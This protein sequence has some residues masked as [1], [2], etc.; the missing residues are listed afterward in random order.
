MKYLDKFLTRQ[1]QKALLAICGLTLLGFILGQFDGFHNLL[2]KKSTIPENTQE[3]V[4]AVQEDKPIQI[5]IRTATKEELILLPGIGEKRAQD[6]I[7]YRNQ[8]GFNST[9]DLLQIKGIGEK[10][11]AKMLPSLLIFG[12]PQFTPE[13]LPASGPDT[14]QIAISDK[15]KNADKTSTNGKA[16]DSKKK[17]SSASVSKSQLSNIVNINTA[18]IEELCTL[19]GIGEVKAKAIIDYRNQNGNFNAVEDILN[20]KGI[21]PKTLEKIRSRI[22]V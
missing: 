8:F 3:L 10:T 13:K 16:T 9:D 4:N 18:G 22:K 19:P 2:A 7:D 1:E 15:S 6:I 5:D 14:S 17:T 21:G 12:N 20:V 11:L